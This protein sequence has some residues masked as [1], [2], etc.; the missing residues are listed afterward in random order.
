M[1]IKKLIKKV[2][3]S[4]LPKGNF[5]EKLKAAW[6]NIISNRNIHFKV[7]QNQNSNLIYETN[8]KE[9]TFFTNQPLYNIIPDFDNY[10]HYY[11]VKEGDVI[12]DGGANVGILT[13]LFATIIKKKGRVYAFEPDK[14]N[15]KMLNSNLSLNDIGNIYSVHKELL[16]SSE[17]IIDFQES[18]TVASSALWFSSEE[19]IVKKKAITLDKWCEVNNI[20]RLDYIKMDIEGAELEAIEG[21]REIIKKHQPN[22]AIAS[23]HMINNEPTYI[24]L[25][26]FFKRINYPC[27]T[28]KFSDYEII[29]FAGSAILNEV[30]K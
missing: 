29:T 24:K 10:Q 17:S 15:I 2:I 30:E 23:Y 21:C 13:L 18:G 6:Y 4:L 26:A 16:W 3:S 1:R 12:I 25:E 27:I 5:K 19:N 9:L 7:I 11:K 14:Y 20:H 22:F 28:K 8:Y